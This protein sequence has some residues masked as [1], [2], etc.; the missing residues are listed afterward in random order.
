MK[1]LAISHTFKF[2]PSHRTTVSV[3][4][5]N[6]QANRSEQTMQTQIRCHKCG[7]WFYTICYSCNSLKNRQYSIKTHCSNFRISV[8]GINFYH[9]GLMQQTTNGN[10]FFSFF[11]EYKL[12]HFMQIVSY[13]LHEMSNPVFWDF[14]FFF[15][16]KCHLLKILPRVL[17]INSLKTGDPEMGNWQTVQT[18]IR[19]RRMRHLIRFS[20]VCK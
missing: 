15:L 18:Q 4:T 12:W 5:L 2:V 19:C 13:N 1:Y 3:F 16:F 8:I 9:T 11:P 6:I 20:T 17:S 10:I 7:I 14:F